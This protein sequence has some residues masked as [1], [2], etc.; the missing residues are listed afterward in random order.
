MGSHTPFLVTP[1]VRWWPMKP[2]GLGNQP[3]GGSYVGGRVVVGVELFWRIF[4][5]E[6]L[7]PQLGVGGGVACF[8]PF[9]SGVYRSQRNWCAIGLKEA[10][11]R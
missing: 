3:F 1:W 6:I 9:M 4:H 8:L 7:L 5:I 10:G 2:Q 11:A